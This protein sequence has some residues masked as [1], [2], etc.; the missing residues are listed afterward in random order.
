MV[1]LVR[2]PPAMQETLVRFLSREVPQEERQATHSSIHRLPSWL[3]WS[4]IRLQRGRPGLDPWVG[5]IPRR[6]EQLPTAIFWP[7]ELH[8]LCNPWGHKEL[9]MTE[10]LSLQ[11]K[12]SP[13]SNEDPAEAKRNS[14][15]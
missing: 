14:F 12:K 4:R 9:G 7:G 1:Q 6:R 10:P 15:L 2:N 5:K 8:G 3:S 11:L 13:H